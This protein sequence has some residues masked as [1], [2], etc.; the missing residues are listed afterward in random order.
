MINDTVLVSGVQQS[1]LV[2]YILVSGFPCWLSSKESACN[3]GELGSIPGSER[4]PGGGC[5]NPLQYSCLWNPVDR[6][7]Q[8]TAVHSHTESDVIEA[9]KCQL[10]HMCI[11]TFSNYFST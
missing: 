3:A 7:A 5:G 11:Y 6:G 1:N 2:I 4:S 8:Q 10:Q 9:T